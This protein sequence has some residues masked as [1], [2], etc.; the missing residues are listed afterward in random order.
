MEASGTF[1]VKTEQLDNYAE[2][3]ND[4]EIGRMSIN[5]IFEG[6]IK[7]TSTGEM[8]TAIT[9]V[10]GSAGY[11]AIEQLQ[12]ELKGKKGSFVLQHFGLMSGSGQRLILEVVP[13]SGTGEL[14]NI[15]GSM[16]ISF[17]DGKHFYEFDYH[18]SD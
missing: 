6:D 3:R 12:G 4:I 9:P 11:V 14:S 1:D 7:A 10:K 16:E 8:L 13:N 5:K 17:T 2:G 18:F 15:R